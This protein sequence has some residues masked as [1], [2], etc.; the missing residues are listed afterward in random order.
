MRWIARLLSTLLDD[1]GCCLRSPVVVTVVLWKVRKQVGR[2]HLLVDSGLVQ[3]L[4]PSRM[5]SCLVYPVVTW[6]FPE[7]DPKE[8]RQ[9]L[10]YC[11]FGVV[12]QVVAMSKMKDHL[13]P[14]EQETSTSTAAQQSRSLFSAK[15]VPILGVVSK[16]FQ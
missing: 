5:K 1:F 11:L 13:P 8:T 7:P 15:M 6:I 3:L 2:D 9:K 12:S 16:G 4:R 10:P 14:S